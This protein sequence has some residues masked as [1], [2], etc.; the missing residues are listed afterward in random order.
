MILIASY[1]I[2]KFLIPVKNS[3]KIPFV[4]LVVFSHA[5]TFFVY[6]KDIYFN[7]SIVW[8][9]PVHFEINQLCALSDECLRQAVN[10][11]ESLGNPIVLFSGIV[12]LILFL[13]IYINKSKKISSNKEEQI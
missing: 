13:I 8:S 4:I 10:M 1:A 7:S 2:W 9:L 3:I 11:K 12:M 5:M 6:W